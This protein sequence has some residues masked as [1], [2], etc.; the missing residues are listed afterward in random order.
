MQVNLTQK[1]KTTS[2]NSLMD[3]YLGNFFLFIFFFFCYY[4]SQI[5]IN[6]TDPHA[7]DVAGCTLPTL[8]YLAREKRPQ[9]P[10]NFKAGAMNALVMNNQNKYTVLVYN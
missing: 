9:Y 3:K 7:K 10:H 8:V 1:D 6:G 4:V 5:L 2:T